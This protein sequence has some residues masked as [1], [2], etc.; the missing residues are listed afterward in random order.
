VFETFALAQHRTQ[1]PQDKS[2]ENDENDGG[3]I[4]LHGVLVTGRRCA[5]TIARPY[6]GWVAL[7]APA[8][9]AAAGGC[10]ALECIL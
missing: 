9:K 3:G 6:E 5:A 8:S 4:N 7:R 2:G 10:N 1:L